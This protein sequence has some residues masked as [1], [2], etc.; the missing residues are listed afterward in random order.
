MTG[1]YCN[2]CSKLII[3][4]CETL[5][6]SIFMTF[7][8]YR[9][10]DN[11]EKLAPCASSNISE[12]LNNT[13]TSLAPKRLHLGDSEAYD[14][15]LGCG[16]ASKNIGPQYMSQT[17]QSANLSPE[18]HT[19]VFAARFAE[20]KRQDS[21]RKSTVQFSRRRLEMKSSRCSTQASNEVREGTM[22]CSGSSS[23]DMPMDTEEI[24]PPIQEPSLF[25]TSC[26][27][28]IVFDLESSGLDNRCEIL[29][30]AAYL[31]SNPAVSFS[32]YVLP[33]R[34]ISRDATAV[35]HL[36]LGRESGHNVLLRNGIEVPSVSW[37]V[38]EKKSSD[39]L[40]EVTTSPSTLVA[41][42]CFS[43]NARVLL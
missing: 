34:Q 13:F 15:R 16:V 11:A 26:N 3:P 31:F 1:I 21:V 42:N 41:H 5:Y 38:A 7:V 22:Y 17:L 6:L 40:G 8:S 36:S 24:P 4:V 39:C 25:Q 28:L 33:T 30:I 23:A 9:Y 35:T 37:S 29:Q 43:F 32:V 12:S 27:N 18:K 2:C 20:T 10:A 19:E 14:F